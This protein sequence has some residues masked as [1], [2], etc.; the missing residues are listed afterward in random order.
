MRL[1][2]LLEG[3][4]EKQAS[5]RDD[6]DIR[7]IAYDSRRV[8]P[9]SLFVAVPGFHLDGHLFLADAASRG[10]A[11]V[12]VQADR[13][14]KV[15]QT[16][17]ASASPP[18][19][20]VVPDSRRALAELAA[21]FFDYP[22]RKLKV[23]GV[24]GT[25]G[26]TTTT[27]LISA[28]LETA[29]YSTGLI[30]TV[31]FKVGDTVWYND[32]RQTTPES[33]EVQELLNRMVA[34]KVDYA[35]IE[36]TSHGLA[37]ERLTGCEYDVAVFTNLS[38][39]HLDFHR[40]REQYL[41]D[42]ARLFEMLGDA[43]DKGIA[44][45]SILN[46]DDASCSYLCRLSPPKI[47][48]YGVENTACVMA[49]DIELSALGTR[50]TAITPLGE[51]ELRLAMGGMFSVYNALAS[52]SVALSQCIELA[53]IKKALESVKGVPG[54]L[55]RIDQGQPF[56]VIVDYAHTPAALEKV[57]L[58]L[59]PLTRGKL[60]VVFGCAGERDRGRRSGMGQVA[61]KLADFSVVTSE[62]PRSEDPAAILDE[63]EKGLLSS[64]RQARNDYTKVVDR[65]DAIRYAF[66][67][68]APGDL[69]LLAGK[70]HEKCIIVGNERIPWD[71]REVAREVL[72][73]MMN[74]K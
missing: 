72:R 48:T 41:R 73:E 14:E 5:R 46:A 59:R 8:A 24:T 13:Q 55:E 22:A 15:N 43:Y 57:L 17:S 20:I 47:I 37:L 26:K 65:R 3:L 61:G 39:D 32:T 58:M 11:A 70:G 67:N 56:T 66:E 7:G 44:K 33:L 4:R 1:S 62:D 45:T 2:T 63:I 60:V 71:D 53:T 50:F 69:V 68:A 6:P 23:I 25:D 28:M 64:G 12:V 31:D 10:A 51:V 49:K 36:S 54:R 38:S 34:E 16:L 9:G 30:G 21:A 29:G 40:T 42:K 52:V 19:V 18:P 35:I 74:D 27:F